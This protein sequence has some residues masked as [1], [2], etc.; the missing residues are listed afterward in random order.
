MRLGTIPDLQLAFGTK[1]NGEPIV[2]Y[3]WA[4]ALKKAAGC[5]GRFFDIDFVKAWWKKN[6]NFK[7]TDVWPC[8][9]KKK[10]KANA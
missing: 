3:A 8:W 6:P 4:Q 1:P 2:S 5:T 10:R 7:M 9:K